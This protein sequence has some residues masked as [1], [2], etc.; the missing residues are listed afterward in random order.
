MVTAR[1]QR[2]EYLTRRWLRKYDVPFQHLLMRD[3]SDERPDVF[4]KTDILA[5]IRGAGFDVVAAIDDNPAVIELWEREQI[6]VTVVPGWNQT[7]A[8]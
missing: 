3:D 7:P 1:K 6:P 5:R 8:A 4:V 2:H